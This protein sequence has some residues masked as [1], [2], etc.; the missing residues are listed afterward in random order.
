MEI[1]PVIDIKN[2]RA[3]HAIKG[4]RDDYQPIKTAL[5]PSSDAVA[6]ISSF[7][8]LGNFK[9][10]YIADLNSIMRQ[11]SNDE[12]LQRI[13]ESFPYINFWIDKGLR[14]IPSRSKQHVN[15]VSV[16]GSE[17]LNE[18][19][20]KSLENPTTPFILSLDYSSEGKMGPDPLFTNVRYWP[21]SI[22]IMTLERVGKN[23]GPDYQ[24]LEYFC[25]RHP[26]RKFIAAGGIRNMEDLLKLK[27]MGIE[28]AL[29]ASALHLKSISAE[30][31]NYLRNEP[32]QA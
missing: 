18:S 21:E 12:L 1:I 13:V 24:K 20:L 27:K 23:D 32:N 5:C 10:I 6:V 9:R 16:I 26:D 29:V 7:I 8:Q 31:I 15:S 17:S 3:V 19:H 4:K 30:D 25:N 11:E 28:R 22:I 2:G 14:K